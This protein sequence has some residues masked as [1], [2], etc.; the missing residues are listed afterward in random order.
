MN[1]T[2]QCKCGKIMD[3]NEFSN[4][5][6]RCVNFKES[7]KKFDTALGELLK[8]YS[9]PKENLKI[10]RI[11][12]KQY[13]SVLDKKIAPR[14]QQDPRG[15]PR[16]F[17]GFPRNP[18][19]MARNDR[20]PYNGQP[21]YP[22]QA[23]YPPQGSDIFNN[24]PKN[25]QS[26]Y[27]KKFVNGPSTQSSSAEISDLTLCEMCKSPDF[28]YLECFH[29]LCT[30]CFK[31]Y[32]EKDFPNMKCRCGAPISEEYKKQVLGNQLYDEL[33]KKFTGALLGQLVE[34]PNCHEKNQY[35]EG[36]IDYNI[37]DDK[38]V[39]LTREAAIDY[40]K[41]RVRCPRC[42]KDFCATCK[43]MPYH[44]GK[45]CEQFKN[46][47]KALKCRFCDTEIKMNNQG[48]QPDV[49]NSQE[50]KDRYNLSCKKTLHCGHH[51][52]GCQNDRTCP[53]CLNSKCEEYK[54]IFNQDA[55]EY[56][57][58]C[59]T[60]GLGSA[61]VVMLSCNH[62]V[63]FTCI[64][65]RLA[66]KWVGPKITFNHCLCPVCNNW[67]ECPSNPD[68]QKLIDENKAL[69]KDICDMA[70]KRLKFEDLDKDPKLTNPQSK[71]YG[72]NLEYAL[73]RLS[74]YMCYSCKKPYFAGR[75]ECGDGPNVNNDNPNQVYDPKDCVCGKCANLSGVAGIT[76][77]K[78]HGKDFIEYK[79]K[80]CCKIAS[81]FCWGTTHFCEDCHKRQCAGDYVSKYPKEKLPKCDP[82]KCELKVKHPPNGEEFAL[83]CSVCRNAEEN[84][85]NF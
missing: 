11:L 15:E 30:N 47:K 40:A 34:C 5:F 59:F 3:E 50:C 83:G 68:I 33:D 49:C 6:Q 46:F 32:A 20:N 36:K 48:P 9:E 35:E 55:D 16:G 43:V 2:I 44:V 67:Y 8:E 28:N 63:H 58:I 52:F 71:W 64:Q 72:K 84:A 57:N 26:I 14:V 29:P 81:W 12:L 38:N 74:Y 31:K 75:R 80:F 61:P 62:F 66:S 76:E 22:P 73:N 13:I 21:G 42:T 18:S 7:F 17:S 19:G 65:K 85:R 4:H 10:I 23:N 27:E 70:L 77:C 39:K 24:Q 56:C 79:C 53:P 25:Q 41:N 1:S 51:C 37:K 82:A 69:Y 60:E 78:K 54:N 45:T